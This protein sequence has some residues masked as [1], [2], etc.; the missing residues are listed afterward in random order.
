[1]LAENMSGHGSLTGS[2]FRISRAHGYQTRRI[3]WHNSS[4]NGIIKQRTAKIK[5]LYTLA[6][7][8]RKFKASGTFYSGF[9]ALTYEEEGKNRGNSHGV[10]LLE[11][12]DAGNVL[13]GSALYYLKDEKRIV[14]R[15]MTLKR[16]AT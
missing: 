10:G 8:G 7:S 2:S 5:F 6:P 14:E 13:S 11:I 1:M 12:N 3:F 16:T 4:G 15:K 9:V